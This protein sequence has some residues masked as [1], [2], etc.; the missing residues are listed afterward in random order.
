MDDEALK[1]YKKAKSVYESV[2]LFAKPLVKEGASALEIVEKIEGKIKELGCGIAFPTNISIN[3]HAAHYTPDIN[4]STKLEDGDI[5]KIDIGVHSEGYICDSAFTVCINQKTHP[6]ID[7]AEKALEES[8]KV[9]KPGVRICDVSEVVESVLEGTGFNPIR[10][11]CGH[12][13]DRYVTHADFSIPNGRNKITEEISGGRALAME[14]FVTDGV[15]W[16]KDSYP[17]LIFG[18]LQDKPIRL[19][20]GRK[21]LQ[22]ARD[23]FSSLPFAKRWI[24]NMGISQLKIDMS[25]KQLIEAGAIREYPILKEESGG[26]VAQA[27]TTIII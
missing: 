25:L 26:L 16:V 8:L 1:N 12:G 17:V 6:L 21:I 20:E 2:S 7:A 3:D 24:G 15:G 9:I 13:L 5:V 10:N 11:L 18:Y 19:P 27:E 22:A 23:D 14:V 4:D